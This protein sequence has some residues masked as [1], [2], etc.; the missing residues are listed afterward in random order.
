[1]E[2]KSNDKDRERGRIGREKEGKGILR[3][4]KR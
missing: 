4:R 2:G 1:M 3:E